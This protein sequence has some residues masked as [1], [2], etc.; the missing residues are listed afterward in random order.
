MLLA[1]QYK[2]ISRFCERITLS[3][4]TVS[5]IPLFLTLASVA[6]NNPNCVTSPPPDSKQSTIFNKMG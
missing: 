3:T 6:A 4:H 1:L 2:L 5:R